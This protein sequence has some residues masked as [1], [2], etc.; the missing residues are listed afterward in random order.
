MATKIVLLLALSFSYAQ[1]EDQ[2]FRNRREY[3]KSR[4]EDFFIFYDFL[5]HFEKSKNVGK[6]ELQGVRQKNEIQKETARKEYLKTRKLPG[7]YTL[8]DQSTET[9]E[10]LKKKDEARAEFIN[11][12]A[13]LKRLERAARKVPEEV[14]SGL[15]DPI[16]D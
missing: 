12:R 13:A 4:Y 8:F 11:H 16:N 6:S 10:A 2:Q 15:V 1:D 9:K 5:D 3:L 14:E 7:P